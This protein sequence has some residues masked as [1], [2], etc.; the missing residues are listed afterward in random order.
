MLGQASEQGKKKS[1]EQ[2]GK[3]KAEGGEYPDAASAL[4]RESELL[5]TL[6]PRFN[7]AGTWPGPAR[8]P[9]WRAT[10]EGLDVAVLV[11][12]EPGWLCHGPIGAG[13]VRLRAAFLR[14]LW[15][16]LHPQRGLGHIWISIGQIA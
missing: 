10:D 15:C 1:R 14:L 6:R 8:F 5:R 7:R 2:G 4:A 12:P 16:A 13:V 3:L 9:A 11:A